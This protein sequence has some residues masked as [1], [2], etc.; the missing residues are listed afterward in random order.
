METYKGWEIIKMVSEGEIEIGTGISST[1]DELNFVFDGMFIVWAEGG[2]TTS[3]V[4]SSIFTNLILDF[5]LTNIIKR[6]ETTDAIVALNGGLTI[7]SCNTGVK[8]KK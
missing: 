4:E 1:D 5:K 6:V 2:D 3:I 8:F 7:E